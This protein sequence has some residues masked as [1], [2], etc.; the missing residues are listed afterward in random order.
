MASGSCPA[1]GKDERFSV[2]G[3]ITLLLQDPAHSI[4]GDL[5][6]ANSSGL[7]VQ[8]R[9]RWFELRSLTGIR[10]ASSERRARVMWV[11]QL[12]GWIE[13]S[14]LYEE[15]YLV[16][17]ALAGDGSAFANLVNPHLHHLHRAIQS[18]LHNPADAEEALQETLLKVA[19]HLDEFHFESEFKPWIYRIGTREALKR[20]RWNRRH[21]HSAFHVCPE[22]DSEQKQVEQI[23]DPGGTPAEILERKEFAGAIAAALASLSEMYRQIFVTCDLKQVPV[24]QAARLFGINIDTANT[25]LYRARMLMRKQLRRTYVELQARTGPRA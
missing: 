20:L 11:R 5:T 4:T 6:A 13:A 24:I 15:A 16:H 9:C 10:C 7:R 14:L 3:K 1:T 21:A 12:D 22:T 23:A 17:R 2:P 25:R 18:I 8:L 19:Q